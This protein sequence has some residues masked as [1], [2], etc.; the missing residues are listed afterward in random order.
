MELVTAAN[1]KDIFVAAT[2]SLADSI[3]LPLT[4]LVSIR[5]G[6]DFFKLEQLPELINLAHR[7]D[8][9]VYPVINGHPHQEQLPAYK[10][11]AKQ[12][13]DSGADG[14]VLGSPEIIHWVKTQLVP[15]APFLIIASSSA[16]A[17]CQP[18]IEFLAQLG[19]RRVII[20][21]LHSLGEVRE[22]ARHTTTQLELFVHGL[23]C[24]CWE[25][26][27]CLIPLYT[28]GEKSDWACCL[29][30][31]GEGLSVA[32]TRHQ[33]ASDNSYLW[34]MR[35]QSDLPFLPWMVESGI[36]SIKV[37][38]PVK[39][40]SGWQRTITIWRQALDR[41]LAEKDLDTAPLTEELTDLSPL[42]IE[43]NLR[44]F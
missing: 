11:A 37:I 6:R 36:S 16:K 30:L 40:I 10:E 5:W 27:D 15:K 17:V 20:S 2:E 32:C 41:A 35:V 19:A 1:N 3:Y 18:D 44:R 33:A 24:P 26:E 31:G 42:P 8:K 25:G 38:P 23:L 4:D 22:L 28:Y 29:E 21:R 9:K 39:D 13:Y 43:F 34:Q 12:I 7:A 14:V